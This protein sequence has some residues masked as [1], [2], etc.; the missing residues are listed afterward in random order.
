[1]NQP[2]VYICSPSWASLPPPSPSHPSGSSQCTSPEHP[3]SWIKP[4]LAIYFTYDNIHISMP[5]TQIIPPLPS[6]TESKSLF[7]TS[8]SFSARVFQSP[9]CRGV[10]FTFVLMGFCLSSSSER[11]LRPIPSPSAKVCW[12]PTSNQQ[13]SKSM[14]TTCQVRANI[15]LH[16][17]TYFCLLL[18]DLSLNF[19]NTLFWAKCTSLSDLLTLSDSVICCF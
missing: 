12:S 10:I 3:V 17:L 11:K 5:F 18:H 15:Y 13:P 14:T 2:W 7:L 4:E 9:H 19:L 6:P 8:V 16:L 1:M